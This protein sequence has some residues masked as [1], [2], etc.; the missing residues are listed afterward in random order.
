MPKSSRNVSAEL[1]FYSERFYDAALIAKKL[2]QA[3]NASLQF[4]AENQAMEIR[5]LT[6]IRA[7]ESLNV[8]MTLSKIVI[9]PPQQSAHAGIQ[10]R[11]ELIEAFVLRTDRFRR[12]LEL[13]EE[14]KLIEKI[15]NNLKDTQW[16]FG[17]QAY[18]YVHVQHLAEYLVNEINPHRTALFSL[19]ED[20]NNVTKANLDAGVILTEKSI[21]MLRKYAKDRVQPPVRKSFSHVLQQF[22]KIE[23]LEWKSLGGLHPYNVTS[24]LDRILDARLF[25]DIFYERVEGGVMAAIARLPISFGETIDDQLFQLQ[26]AADTRK[27]S[28]P[29]I[30]HQMWLGTASPPDEVLQAA[31]KCREM[32]EANGWRYIRWNIS[33]LRE[34]GGIVPGLTNA[35][36]MVNQSTYHLL[37]DTKR[38]S[39]LHLYGGVYTDIIDAICIHPF[40]PLL[41]Y[42]DKHRKDLIVAREFD[43]RN[44]MIANGVL[45]ATPVSQSLLP[46]A[47]HLHNQ[48]LVKRSLANGQASERARARG[49]GA[50]TARLTAQSSLFCPSNELRGQ[51]KPQEARLGLFFASCCAC[52]DSLAPS[53]V[54]P[55]SGYADGLQSVITALITV[56]GIRIKNGTES[57][58]YR[59]YTAWRTSGPLLVTSA[60]EQWQSWMNIAILPSSA[61]YP[62]HVLEARKGVITGTELLDVVQYLGSYTIHLWSGTSKGNYGHFTFVTPMAPHF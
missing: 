32:H 53:L 43:A 31:E 11:D 27:G 51:S 30:L 56:L 36:R 34:I 40:D 61:F 44:N 49:R 1:L 4:E 15:R 13:L 17:C 16:V 14:E 38:L 58:N 33:T 5:F 60:A 50:K 25:K 41:V 26:L 9:L 12:F 45:I 7:A 28:V 2:W 46:V 18:T 21:T 39:I 19:T 48:T 29:R 62:I 59:Q 55:A 23:K 8:H 47:D 24:V 35:N 20:V 57:S 22:A 10:S 37:A 42:A 6:R 52:F 3:K 54:R